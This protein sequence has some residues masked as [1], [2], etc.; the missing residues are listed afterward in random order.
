MISTSFITGTGFM[1]CMPMKRSGRLV[2]PAR[3]VMEM[4]EVLVARIAP[5]L[6][7]RRPAPRRS[8]S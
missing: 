4:E 1:K 7:S 5:S 6:A 3:R 2:P 8:S